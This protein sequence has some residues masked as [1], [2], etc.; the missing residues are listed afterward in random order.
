M[1]ASL[2]CEGRLSAQQRLSRGPGQNAGGMCW[3][4]SPTPREGTFWGPTQPAVR[5]G[6]VSTRR[7]GEQFGGGQAEAGP[8]FASGTSSAVVAAI[9]ELRIL[10]LRR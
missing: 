10:D 5:R 7:R 3:T 1:T 8:S 4:V 9:L 2:I 6:G